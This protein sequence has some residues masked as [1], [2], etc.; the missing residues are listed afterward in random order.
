MK[1]TKCNEPLEGSDWAS[2]FYELG[3]REMTPTT[4]GH[5]A[6]ESD[7]STY[8]IDLCNFCLLQVLAFVRRGP[9]GV[10]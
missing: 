3:P 5:P 6:E 8:Q 4:V 1:C 9:G 10:G 2:L 7:G